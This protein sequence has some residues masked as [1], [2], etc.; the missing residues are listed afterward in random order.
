MG[1][2]L[3]KFG[4]FFI[5]AAGLIL[6]GCAS[7]YVYPKFE[8]VQKVGAAEGGLADFVLGVERSYLEEGY[9]GMPPD[10]GVP[11]DLNTLVDALNEYKVFKRTAYMDQ[12]DVKPHL[13]LKSYRAAQ[14][15]FRG[16]HG[17]HGGPLCVGYYYPIALLTLTVLP[18]YCSSEE[19]VSFVLSRADETTGKQ[20]QFTRQ[21]K[22]LYGAWAPVV[23]AVN[24]NWQSTGGVKENEKSS[25]AKME[26]AERYKK[27]LVKKFRELEPSILELSKGK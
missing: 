12:L 9:R 14:P 22:F 17:E 8:D 21:K 18:I 11:Y 6:S 5:V 26:L 25:S 10:I 3:L 20:F 19:Q 24:P 15:G 27:F 23:A 7:M 13:V 16:I 4:Y 2:R 1:R